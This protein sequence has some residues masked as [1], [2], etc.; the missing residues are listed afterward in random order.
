MGILMQVK[1]QETSIP[2]RMVDVFNFCSFS[3]LHIPK[4]FSMSE[5]RVNL[6]SIDARLRSLL[7]IQLN[8]LLSLQRFRRPNPQFLFPKRLQMLLQLA[9][10]SDPLSKI[11]KR[12]G[13]DRNP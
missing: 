8:P 3:C 12:E 9:P 6:H 13:N 7:H 1:M 2:P 11:D 4:T 5:S 10:F